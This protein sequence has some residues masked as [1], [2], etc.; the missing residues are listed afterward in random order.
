MSIQTKFWCQT[1]SAL[2]LNPQAL[3]VGGMVLDDLVDGYCSAVV[4]GGEGGRQ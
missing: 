1:S 2:T 3:P 4:R